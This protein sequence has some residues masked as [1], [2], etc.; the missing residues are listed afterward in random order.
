MKKKIICFPFVGDKI[1]GSHISTLLLFKELK[2]T[3]FAPK[4]VVHSNGFFTEYLKD[5]KI[6]YFKLK[7]KTFLGEKKFFQI[8][9]YNF[10]KTIGE[11]IFFL[12]KKKIDIVHTNDTRIHLTWT[13]A[14]RLS[15]CKVVWHQRTYF[16]NWKLY[17][18]IS[19]FAHKII[20]IS[21]YVHKSL[22]NFNKKISKIFYNPFVFY[23]KKVSKN[24]IKKK[25]LNKLKV[26]HSKKII[27]YIANL[28]ERKKPFIFLKIAE[29]L[30]KK[31]NGEAIFIMLGAKRDN[32]LFSRILEFIKKRN[33][34]FYLGFK[35]NISDYIYA[36]D[37]FIAPYKDEPFGRT[38]I[39]SM[40]LQTLVL[41]SNSGAHG[42]IIIDRANGFLFKEN[43]INRIS[44][45][46]FNILRNKN[47]MRKIVKTAYQT[48]LSNYSISQHVKKVNQLYNE[49]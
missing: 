15:G 24:S 32:K 19:I 18:F 39:E 28:E 7:N 12:K 16:P 40:L 13:I 8:N 44:Q 26:Y 47:K 1:G 36:S 29:K 27:L 49:L 45:L 46:A 41:A 2:K 34:I 25:I 6:K 5:K 35:K 38:L 22:P 4:I 21:K 20:S 30:Q 11:I 37:L 48:S 10:F 17:R 31:L 14:A 33:Y 42:E 43:N 9:F 3:F 23:K